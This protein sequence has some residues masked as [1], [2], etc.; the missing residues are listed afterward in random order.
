MT[1][2]KNSL[3]DKSNWPPI[4]DPDIK[5]AW[6]QGLHNLHSNFRMAYLNLQAQQ[7]CHG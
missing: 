2:S 3:S 4:R 7:H 1:F 5:V 6:N